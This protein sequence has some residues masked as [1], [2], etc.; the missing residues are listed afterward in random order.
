MA[1]ATADNLSRVRAQCG[2]HACSACSN[3]QR[4]ETCS[5]VATTA[6]RQRRAD[7][8]Y[9]LLAQA[10]G[11]LHIENGWTKDNVATSARAFI[12]N[13]IFRAPIAA[14]ALGGLMVV[15][16]NLVRGRGCYW[17]CQQL[18]YICMQAWAH[19]PLSRTSAGSSRMAFTHCGRRAAR[20]QMSCF[21]LVR[22]SWVREQPGFGYGAIVAWSFVMSFLLLMVG[23]VLEGFKDV[24][25]TQLE[26]S[27]RGR[28][29]GRVHACMYACMCHKRMEPGGGMCG[30]MRVCMCVGGG[31]QQLRLLV[32]AQPAG[33]RPTLNRPTSGAAALPAQTI[34]GRQSQRARSPA[35]IRSPTSSPSC[36]PLHYNQLL[37]SAHG[38]S[39]V[40]ILLLF[41]RCGRWPAPAPLTTPHPAHPPLPPPQGSC[42]SSWCCSCC[43]ARSQLSWGSMTRCRHTSA[44]ASL[45]RLRRA[46]ASTWRGC[47]RDPSEQR[48]STGTL[49]EALPQAARAV[50]LPPLFF[51][52]RL[53]RA[54]ARSTSCIHAQ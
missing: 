48:C 39:P 17:P 20:P 51:S 13:S 41:A 52:A 18:P 45:G 35:R 27:E 11:N 40:A 29:G 49:I 50:S 4:E 7:S 33:L 15:L 30:C 54:C 28:W 34:A 47:S 32:Y 8:I 44:P 46:A 23:L 19:A 38:I 14:C 26:P 10:S 1:W 12:S 25:K 21:V 3:V 5:C 53:Q 31:G 37:S 36:E 42:S 2:A 6:C 16:F 24:V 22:R 9:P 43:S